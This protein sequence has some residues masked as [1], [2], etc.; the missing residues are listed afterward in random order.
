MEPEDSLQHSQV[1]ANCPYP[2]S[3]HS[4]KIHLN[5]ILPSTP[6][7]NNNNNTVVVFNYSTPIWQL[8]YIFEHVGRNSTFLTA[9]WSVQINGSIWFILKIIYEVRKVDY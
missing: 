7:N 2:E 9:D 5:I 1:P 6:N 8:Q 3:A 4:L